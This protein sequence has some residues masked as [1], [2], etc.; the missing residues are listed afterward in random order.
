MGLPCLILSV[1]RAPTKPAFF[2]I[3][4]HSKITPEEALDLGAQEFIFKAV[5][6]FANC[7]RPIERHLPTVSTLHGQRHRHPIG[8]ALKSSLQTSS[9]SRLQKQ[10]ALWWDRRVAGNARSCHP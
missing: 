2:L 10:T 8:E 5:Q 3:T 1:A 4:G 6:L 7:S 9:N